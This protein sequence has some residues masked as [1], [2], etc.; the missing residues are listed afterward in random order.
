MYFD[1]CPT[2]FLGDYN[3]RFGCKQDTGIASVIVRERGTVDQNCNKFGDQFL[4]FLSDANCCVVNGRFDITRD[5][6]TSVSKRGV[7]T[8]DY[9][10]VPYAHLEYISD[11]YV[12]SVSDAKARHDI[13]PHMYAKAPDHSLVT[14]CLRVTQFPEFQDFMEP[15]PS[16]RVWARNGVTPGVT[17]AAVHR[18]YRVDALPRDLFDNERTRQCLHSITEKLLAETLRQDELDDVYNEFTDTIHNEM[19]QKLDFK[20]YSPSLKKRRKIAKPYWTDELT[21]L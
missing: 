13:V 20:D 10:F 14:C 2:V 18:R 9:I 17:Q 6:Y 12:T 19:D 11:F 7:A 16:T 3:A 8:V 5:N 4:D 21:A 1:G 15:R